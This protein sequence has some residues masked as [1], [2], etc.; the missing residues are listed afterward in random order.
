MVKDAEEHAAD[1][2]ERRETVEARNQAE[3]LVHQTEKSLEEHGDKVEAE[4]KAEIEGDVAA[5]KEALE[6]E[7][8]E[9]VQ[10][11]LEALVQSS[12]KLGEA[13]YKADQAEAEEGMADGA[14]DGEAADGPDAGP[15]E[16]IVDADF[17]EVDDDDD[18]EDRKDQSSAS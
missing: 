12:M 10:T 18:D 2:K 4:V 8:G 7:D 16:T 3:T 9:L 11:K 17:E 15:E 5:L 13:I 6:G 1:D 14:A